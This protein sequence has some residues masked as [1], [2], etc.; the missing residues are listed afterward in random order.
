[1]NPPNRAVAGDGSDGG[2]GS[3]GAGGGEEAT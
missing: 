1:V 2:H 3:W